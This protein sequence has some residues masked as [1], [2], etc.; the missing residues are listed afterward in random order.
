M[1]VHIR[2]VTP[3]VETGL[4]H[5]SDFEGI[6]SS[7]DRVSFTELDI[8]PASI[9]SGF[10]QMIAAPDTVAKMIEAEKEGVDAVVIDCMEDPG[11]Q[12]GRECV[13]IPVLG[14]CET[15][16]NVACSLGHRFSMLAVT[17]N[18]GIQFENQARLYGAWE[19]YAST[20]SVE[21]PVLD[22]NSQSQLLQQKLF[23]QAVIAIKTDGADTIIIGCTGMM[24]VAQ[25]LQQELFEAGWSVPVIDPIP[26]TVRL[27]KVL[28]ETGISHSK[29]AYPTPTRK[30]MRGYDGT[31]LE[32]FLE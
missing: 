10:D 17:E 31:A 21:I 5:A 20:R 24:N 22:L 3:V 8:G 27:A 28:V 9:E 12:P 11:R 13:S 18:M 16:M 23:E 19:K 30:L 15:S 1:S 14:P 29:V 4:T 32:K 26:L 6:L 7:D 25:R 2:V